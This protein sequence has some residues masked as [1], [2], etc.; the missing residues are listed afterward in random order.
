MR[1]L[2]LSLFALFIGL[3]LGTKASAERVF[4][5]AQTVEELR[6]QISGIE[7][8]LSPSWSNDV[9]NADDYLKPMSCL[10]YYGPIGPYG[11]I[12][13]HGPVGQNIWN[14]TKHYDIAQGWGF[15]AII[16]KANQGP[17]TEKGPLGS[18]GIL[19]SQ[20]WADQYFRGSGLNT[21]FISHLR[22]MGLW[23]ILGPAGPLGPLGPNG[24]LGPVGPHGLKK[25]D[26]GQWLVT[27]DIHCI[28]D[29]GDPSVCRSIEVNWTEAGPT[30]RYDLVEYYSEDFAK[31]MENNDTSFLV[32]GR[33]EA[34]DTGWETDS[35]E[36][37]A[38]VDQVVSLTLLANSAAYFFNQG[39][40]ILGEAAWA[41]GSQR[42]EIPTSVWVPNAFN[43]FIGLV[44]PYKHDEHFDNFDLTVEVKT[45]RAR[46]WTKLE[47]K[48]K[49]I[50]DWMQV[51]VTKGTKLRATISLQQA[52]T[53]Q[54]VDRSCQLNKY[55]CPPPYRLV[56]TG[57]TPELSQEDVFTGPYRLK[58]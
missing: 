33:M 56:V 9:L 14:V 12:S 23:G 17:L 40:T 29:S 19:N 31:K 7:P 51:K 15:L 43:P 35:Y 36:F 3:H 24:P 44:L 52:W 13:Q 10:G 38:P 5:S 2:V 26:L 30:R 1:R 34:K 16:A 37:T 8:Q 11:V 6:R 22:P 45:P 21:E 20:L 18:T 41:P 53:S 57:S 39:M 48:S 28:P 25:N 58:Y 32:D 27:K 42:Y 54:W 50:V 46:K 49:D 47:T 55:A 4:S